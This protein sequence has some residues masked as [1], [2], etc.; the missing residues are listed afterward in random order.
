M[1]GRSHMKNEHTDNKEFYLHG[2]D[3]RW[4][5]VTTY[6]KNEIHEEADAKDR[7][8]ADEIRAELAEGA[9]SL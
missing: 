8:R 3:W 2:R 4:D 1:V 5:G 7:Y 9:Y 6:P